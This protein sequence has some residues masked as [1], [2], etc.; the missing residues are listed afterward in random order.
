MLITIFIFIVIASS[1]SEVEKNNSFVFTHVNVIPMDKDV[2]F[3]DCDVIVENGKIKDFVP[4]SSIDI[5]K[6]ATVIN[7]TGKF[8][9]P[10]FSDMHVHLEGDAWNIIYPLEGRFSKEEIDYNDILFVY[11]ANGIT[12]ID[13]MSAFPEH[14]ELREKINNNDLLG[15]RLILSRLIDGAGKAWPEPISTWVENAVEAKQAVIDAHIKGYDRIK[16]YSFLDKSSYDTILATADSLHMP[17]DGH[18][19]FSTSVE[20][21]IKSGQNMIAHV[22]EIMKF[23]KEYSPEQ[24]SHFASL[25]AESDIWVTSTL[26]TSHNLIELLENDQQALSKLGTE[27]LHPMGVD[28]QIFINDKLYQPIP[29]EQRAVIKNGYQAFQ[30][31]FVNEFNK[32]GGKLLAGT[33]ALI[34]STLPGLSLHKELKELTNAGM[35]PFEALETATVNPYKF[36]GELNMGGT[37]A[38]GKNANLVLLDENPLENISNTKKIF[39][40]MTQNK[41]IS[42]NEIDNRLNEIVKSYAELRNKKSK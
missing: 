16:A 38:S 15:P 28:L 13:V 26:I 41:W 14:I 9:V 42:K 31:P 37:I 29:E 17:V 3:T 12:M 40:V 34:A 36:L 2:V 25:I 20:Y 5:P 6:G 35:S 24:I 8:M 32:K 33:D 23:V 27:Y 21:T 19:P 1:Y 7:A 11:I 22:E 39:G 4:S 18:I 10:A 30:I